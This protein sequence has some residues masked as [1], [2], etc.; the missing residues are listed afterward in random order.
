MR[1]NGHLMWQGL[2]EVPLQILKK[3]T[4]VIRVMLVFGLILCLSVSCEKSDEP[5]SDCNLL[6]FGFLKIDNPNLIQDI[7]GT[8]SANAVQVEVPSNLDV[9]ALKPTF[10]V[11]PQAKATVGAN[12]Q[13]DH[14]TLN[15]FSSQ[16]VFTIVAED[17]KTMDYKISVNKV[18]KLKEVIPLIKSKWMTFT[19]PYNAYFPYNAASKNAINGH[20]GNACG[21]TA[22]AK[23]LHYLK[24]PVNGVGVIDYNETVT[25]VPLYWECDLSNLNLNYNNMPAQLNKSDPE[26]KYKDVANLFLATASV[27][28]SLVIWNRD[29]KPELVPGLVKYFKLDPGLR[30]V[31]RWEVTREQWI[32]MLMKELTAGRPVMVSGR[33]SDSPAP[34]GSGSSQGHWF[35]VDGYDAKGLFHVLYNYGNL[36]MY[37]DA[38]NLG[39][40]YIAYNQAIVGFKAK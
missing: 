18:D 38:D 29:V 4:K 30:L 6:T 22:L 8:V 15:N 33:T 39:E 13:L 37:S 3:Q 7:M 1:K 40:R 35:N 10:A 17:G 11:S 32:D 24:Y 21:P 25:P 16:L 20:E 12:A 9:T 34:W 27:G 19:Y 36:E 5:S 2:Y 31:N 26:S 23:I 28:H 14:L